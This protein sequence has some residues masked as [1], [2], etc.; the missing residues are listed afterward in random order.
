MKRLLAV[1][2]ALTLAPLLMLQ[3]ARAEGLRVFPVTLEVTAP[4]ATSVVTL[5]NDGREPIT[6]QARVFE[7]TQDAGRES[8][9]ATRKV[10]ASPPMT[11]L[12]PGAT[13]VVRVIRTNKGKVSGEEAYRV[14]IDELPDLSRNQ[15]GTVSFVTRLRLP[16]F[17]AAPGASPANVEWRIARRPEGSFLIGR[18]TGQTHLRVADLHLQR[19]GQ[20]VLSRDGLAGYVL[21]QST[22]R[23]RVPPQGGG[24]LT[25][26]ANTNLGQ[27]RAAVGAR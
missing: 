13:Q 15:A 23:F 22:M 16:L 9:S 21:G 27:Y 3:T 10:V 4:G 19:N 18:N 17:F 20:T 8:F 14:F 2:L 24:A 5:K 1:S 11:Q 12:A 26:R 6:V 7:W 25:L